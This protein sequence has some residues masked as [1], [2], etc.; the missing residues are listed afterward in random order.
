M[1]LWWGKKQYLTCRVVSSLFFQ[2]HTNFQIKHR[3]KGTCR[4]SLCDDYICR[5][6]LSGKPL[7]FGRKSPGKPWNRSSFHCWLPRVTWTT[8]SFACL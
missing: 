1:R 6:K 5:Q 4:R 8:F 2:Q 7:K 3:M